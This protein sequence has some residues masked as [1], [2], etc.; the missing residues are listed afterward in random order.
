MAEAMVWICASQEPAATPVGVHVVLNEYQRTAPCAWWQFTASAGGAE[1]P[2]V[3]T[4]RMPIGPRRFRSSRKPAH[5]L[6]LPTVSPLDVV[7]PTTSGVV[8][9]AAARPGGSA[10]DHTTTAATTNAIRRPCNI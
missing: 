10:A 4:R 2:D 1:P 3:K 5:V 6:P 8:A 7:A 9:V